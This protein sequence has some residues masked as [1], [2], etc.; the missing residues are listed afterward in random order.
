MT[1]TNTSII[2]ASIPT[3]HPEVGKTLKTINGEID[4]DAALDDGSVL[5][6]TLVLSLD[7]YMRG[8]MRAPDVPSYRPPFL[9]GEPIANFAVSIVVK[10]NVRFLPHI[11]HSLI[12]L[13]LSVQP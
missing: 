9:V 2:L 13:H 6:K 8:R 5:L 11:F 1:V 3:H 10:S 12:I 7:P 4:L